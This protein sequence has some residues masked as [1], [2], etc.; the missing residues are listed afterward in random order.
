MSRHLFLQGNIG[1]GKS[2]II[3]ENILPHLDRIGG[4]FVQRVFIAGRHV[5]FKLKP[6]RT[7]KDYE[8]NIH[9]DSL[10]G[11]EGLF[12]YNRKDNKWQ[13]DLQV[14]EKY[15]LNYL[16]QG[17][18]APKKILLMDELGGVELKCPVFMETVLEA[19]D[20]TTPVLG[21]LKS[22]RNLDKLKRGMDA[23]KVSNLEGE[24][25]LQI[26]RKHPQVELF[27][28]N[29]GNYDQVKLKVRKFVGD[30]LQ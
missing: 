23:G 19:L 1:I 5:A 10:D 18:E 9:I 11:E 12:L 21:V 27:T 22:P 4:Y 15:G 3:R 7:A 26:I 24:H 8:L 16:K 25:Y 13:A 14:F 20:G 28:I 6:V 30:A 29:A 2:S 17:I